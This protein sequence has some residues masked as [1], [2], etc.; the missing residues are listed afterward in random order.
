M[1]AGAPRD[2]RHAKKT[3]VSVAD[4]DHA[5]PFTG[6]RAAVEALLSAGLEAP[7]RVTAAERVSEE[8]RRNLLLRCT[9]AGADGPTRVIVKQVVADA[10]DPDAVDSWDVRRF[11]GD[12]AGA[13]FLGEVAG[14][15]PHGPR[16]YGGDRARGLIVLEDLG[17]HHS[18][19]EPLLEGDAAG[20]EQGSWPSRAASARCMPI[21]SATRLAS[22]RSRGRST[23]SPRASLRRA[24]GRR[25]S[26]A[27]R[28]IV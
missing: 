3:R 26:C 20:A 27:S 25:T 13:E 23:R 22:R 14:E 4:P 10:Y 18:L 6:Q 19:V 24:S 8:G 28:P 16:F 9:V 17:E 5:D 2:R 1:L 12:W 7:V 11:F 15:S 21:R